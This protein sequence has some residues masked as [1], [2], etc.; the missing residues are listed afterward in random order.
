MAGEI[1]LY[2][3]RPV[4]TPMSITAGTVKPL[5]FILDGASLS[6]KTAQI[7][8]RER[9]KRAYH[10]TDSM[11]INTSSG[12]VSYTLDDI[13]TAQA[14]NYELRI[15]LF[16]G[17]GNVEGRFPGGRGYMVE[18]EGV[19]SEETATLLSNA[20]VAGVGAAEARDQAVAA[21]KTAEMNV[22][23]GFYDDPVDLPSGVEDGSREYVWTGDGWQLY[24]Y[25]EGS[26]TWTAIGGLIGTD[27][28][29]NRIT[30]VA[31]SVSASVN[32]R[33][34]VLDDGLRTGSY[35]LNPSG[36]ASFI[37]DGMV[38][39]ASVGTWDR[40][41][42]EV[43]TSWYGPVQNDSGEASNNA[44]KLQAAADAAARLNYVLVVDGDY[45][46]DTS[47]LEIKTDVTFVGKIL[48]N[49]DER[50]LKFSRTTT[51]E[52]IDPTSWALSG[53][54]RDSKRISELANYRGYTVTF[55]STEVAIERTTGASYYK[56][57]CFTVISDD[58]DIHPGLPDTFTD[59]ANLTVVAHPYDDPI[60]VSGIDMD[61]VLN[62]ATTAVM[63]EINRSNVT[64][65]KPKVYRTGNNSSQSYGISISDCSNTTLNEPYID[66]FNSSSLGYGINVS[67][68]SLITVNDPRIT[69]C[70]H[71]V[72]G[73]HGYEMRFN[74]GFYDSDI[75][76]HWGY[77]LYVNNATVAGSISVCG[78]GPI[79]V[80]DSI[81]EETKYIIKIRDD[82]PELRSDIIVKDC[83]IRNSLE[84]GNVQVV[85]YSSADQ[86]YSFPRRLVQPQSVTIDNVK[87]TGPGL[88][89]YGV[90]EKGG[91]GAG[92]EYDRTLFG[93][94]SIR[95]LHSPT[96]AIRP[97][98]IHK[99]A[100]FHTLVESSTPW[101]LTTDFEKGVYA[102]HG[103]AT[104]LCYT[105]HES[106]A[107]DE[108]GVGVNWTDNWLR[109]KNPMVTLEDMDGWA[110]IGTGLP[111][112]IIKTFGA[113]RNDELGYQLMVNRF[114]N[115]QPDIHEDA[116]QGYALFSN[117][118]MVDDIRG[119]SA[120]AWASAT[121]FVIG[122]ERTESDL[123]YVCQTNHT[124]AGSFATDLGSG[125]W[126]QL[127]PGADINFDHCDFADDFV[128]AHSGIY[129]FDGGYIAG[130]TTATPSINGRVK[131]SSSVSLSDTAKSW[132][133][134]NQIARTGVKTT[135]SLGPQ[136]DHH[137]GSGD[138]PSWSSTTYTDAT[139]YLNSTTDESVDVGYSMF[140]NDGVNDRRVKS[141]INGL[142]RV[143]GFWHHF[144]SGIC[145]FVLGYGT[146]EVM[147]VEMN[148][149][150]L[151]VGKMNLSDLPTSDP[152]EAGELWND[153][154]TVKISA[155]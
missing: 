118:G 78:G 116:I 1:T 100:G 39:E 33:F 43:R 151:T 136:A 32:R 86:S 10:F 99:N 22:L 59:L 35:V 2:A 75:D 95:R 79:I 97:V 16:D 6:G 107:D 91:I 87:Y 145:D 69:N 80:K 94:I 27:L 48:V 85:G 65:E 150:R 45:Y 20:I 11:T 149:E 152:T 154:G 122:D 46:V 141:F 58:G 66:G 4:T 144:S 30:D 92:R 111:T 108:P 117:C 17:A 40:V 25:D 147:R 34:L 42:Q 67:N 28:A 72:S 139:G 114:R 54:V 76:T 123:T 19:T 8:V 68:A 109:V 155:G 90:F 7:R 50:I 57:A 93:D 64:L 148:D 128:F 110:C 104:Y 24:E 121:S 89:F 135:E 49:S 53:L 9:G 44:T 129:R 84:T 55:E 138:N 106:V 143:F 77:G 119:W 61:L 51:P 71:S 62:S 70:K 74:G 83:E 38:L 105:A 18:I 113:D 12:T 31:D 60:K 81:F 26:D 131:S 120:A 101:A 103:G 41:D 5:S 153:S 127:N 125:Y 142:A 96:A 126:L 56:H 29:A 36:N 132:S 140:S 133:T 37:D 63:I 98:D 124:S 112:C 23:A 137:V 134:A 115:F 88:V 82:T 13:Q 102:T 52:S 130:R 3:D 14:G 73:R 21:A 146:T 47:T 15:I